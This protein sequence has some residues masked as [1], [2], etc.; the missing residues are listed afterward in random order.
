MKLEQQQ[1]TEGAENVEIFERLVLTLM[2]R[3]ALYFNY[4]FVPLIKRQSG[5][6]GGGVF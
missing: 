1:Q 2:Q 3:G 6:G 5:R 4:F